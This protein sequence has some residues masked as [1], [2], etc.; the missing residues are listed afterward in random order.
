[1]AAGRPV[2]ATTREEVVAALADRP[3]DLAGPAR[4]A[5]RTWVAV[6]DR[7]RPVFAVQGVV[8]PS[9]D[10]FA[11]HEDYFREDGTLDHSREYVASGVTVYERG[12]GGGWAPEVP[13]SPVGSPVP[14]APVV[15]RRTDAG[16]QAAYAGDPEQ[17][18]RIVDAL[19]A[20]VELVGDER[21]HGGPA[22]HYRARV[23]RARVETLP[24][25]LQEELR[26]WGEV[27]PIDHTLDVW[28]DGGRLRQWAYG[29]E[30]GES[31]LAVETE[32]WDVGAVAAPA[33]PEGVPG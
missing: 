2:D 8:D 17:R 28:V 15:A 3:R 22:R 12:P 24:A 7:R 1:V 31:G 18:A 6:H 27:P 20:S 23:E 14:L 30:P 11:G 32:Y 25:D 10:V 13:P 16:G 9:R 19:V 33:L 26:R 29:P 21:L 5:I 4:Y